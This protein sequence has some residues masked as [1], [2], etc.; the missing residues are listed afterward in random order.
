MPRMKDDIYS[1]R[2]ED[3]VIPDCSDNPELQEKW[4]KLDKLISAYHLYR[5]LAIKAGRQFGPGPVINLVSE[6]VQINVSRSKEGKGKISVPSTFRQKIRQWKTTEPDKAKAAME[7]EH[8]AEVHKAFESGVRPK[9]ATL[10]NMVAA[11]K[12]VDAEQLAQTLRFL[13]GLKCIE[14]EDPAPFDSIIE[15]NKSLLAMPA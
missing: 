12:D 9:K 13:I 7:E 10:F 5:G 4:E 1:L 8:I 14:G 11:E 3:L 6:I 15:E 2:P